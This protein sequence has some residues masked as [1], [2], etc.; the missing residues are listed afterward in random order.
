MIGI[1]LIKNKINSKVYVGS[2]NNIERRFKR[3]KTELNTGKHSN[4][5]LSDSFKKYGKNCFDFIILEICKE[6]N[7]IS[8]ENYYITLYD[9]L[10]PLKG[11][12]LKSPISHPSKVNKEYSKILSKSKLGIKPSNFLE[13]QKTRWSSVRVYINNNFYKDYESYSQAEIELGINRGYIYSY[14][15]QPNCKRRKYENYKFERI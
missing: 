4:K 6:E 7:L 10:N 2:S 14:F 8:R 9:S 11:Y 15:K 1:Y 3:H 5:F 12:N 13:M